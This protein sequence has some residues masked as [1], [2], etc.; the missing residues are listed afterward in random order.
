VLAA[1]GLPFYVWRRLRGGAAA[2]PAGS[3]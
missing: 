2:A 3:A 1:A